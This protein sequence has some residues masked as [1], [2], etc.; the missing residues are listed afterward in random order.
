MVSEAEI[1]ISATDTAFDVPEKTVGGA[2]AIVFHPQPT[3]RI[4]G[5]FRAPIIHLKTFLKI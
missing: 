5:E 4:L 2:P 1:I 3:K